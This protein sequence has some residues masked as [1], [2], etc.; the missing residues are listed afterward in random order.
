MT[1]RRNERDLALAGLREFQQEA[2]SLRASLRSYE[3]ALNRVGRRIERG[4]VLHEAMDKVGLSDLRVDVVE[5]LTS[6]EVARHRMRVACFRMSLTEGLS[7]TE[8][9]RLWGISRQLASRV[10]KE[11][12]QVPASQAVQTAPAALPARLEDMTKG[13]S[14]KERS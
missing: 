2:A 9:A 1:T 5:R 7:M 13:R 6:F 11:G 3:T 12:Q 8:V 4:D 10:A 14:P